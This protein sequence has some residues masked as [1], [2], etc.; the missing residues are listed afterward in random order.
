MLLFATDESFFAL[1]TRP[2]ASVV[3]ALGAVTARLTT[4]FYEV[5]SAGVTDGLTAVAK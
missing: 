1:T 2:A 5:I 4:L 3:T